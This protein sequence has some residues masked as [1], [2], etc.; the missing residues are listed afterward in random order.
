MAVNN[1]YDQGSITRL[2]DEQQV[3]QKAPVIFGTNDELGAAHGVYEIIANAID[4][5][6]EGY[7]KQIRIS[8]EADGTVEVSDDGR[9]VPMDWNKNEQEYNWRLVFCTMY[10]SGKYD[11]SNYSDSLGTNGLG[12]T[13]MQYASEFMDVYSTR[14][15]YT[16][17]MHFEKGRPVG[18]LQKLAPIRTGTGTTIRFK[19]DPEVFTGIRDMTMP[20]EY[21]INLL[22]RQAMLHAGLEIVLNHAGLEK[23]VSIKYDDGI[24]GFI[25]AICEK[26]ML[27]KTMYFEESVI[28]DNS[29]NG[30]PKDN[31]KY[32]F[33]ERIAFNFSRDAA[34]IEMYHNGANL[35]EG[36]MT[37]EG[38]RTGMTKGFEYAAKE[39]GKISQNSKFV[40]KDIEQILVCVCDTNAP[41]YLTSFKNQTKSAVLNRNL[42]Q[43]YMQF[44]YACIRNWYKQDKQSVDKIVD[45]IIV[46]KKAREEAESV[47]RKVI[48]T[49]S[50]SISGIG[51]KPKKFVDCKSQFVPE[52]EIW[53]V[54]GDSAAGSCK[55]ARDANFQGIMP[56]RGKVINCLKEDLSRVLNS[57]IVLDLLRIFGCGIEAESKYIK[58]LPKFDINK[59]NW[60]KIIICTDADID[61]MQI[62][63]LVL[64][65][66]Y[67][68]CPTL[69][70]AGKVFIAETPLFEIIYKK[71][72]FFAYTEEEKVDIMQKL[73]DRG[74]KP[75]QIKVNR[76][77][78]LGENDPEMMNVSTMN[79]TTRR[80]VPVEFPD[81]EA[82][83][84]SVFSALLGSD[85]ESRRMLIEE[86]FSITSVD[87]E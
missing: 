19:P 8:V 25:D 31:E 28:T 54:E 66:L 26:P 2:K 82:S 12:A 77:K 4:E 55:L 1:K 15:G 27:K 69:L 17:Y 47:S 84:A 41:G 59:L 49:M 37:L 33:N 6:R 71:E 62:R 73:A 10:A 3:R 57:D 70:R 42:G 52:R 64:T 43:E 34:L 74:I 24:A 7:G 46:N 21:Y 18:K 65:M 32:T 83:V 44:V 38:L 23:P 58:D 78:G 35:F 22:R 61:G 72:T 80:L 53:I 9:G 86:F 11:G 87:V 39:S 40:F 16:Y 13:A 63:C 14:D 36:G 79:P 81:D 29:S 48:S 45:E 85:I 56:V 75:N 51:N 50:K 68:L 76:S 30:N 5:A 67:K 60:G 20:P